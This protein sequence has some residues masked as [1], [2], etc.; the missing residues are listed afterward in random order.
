VK[1]CFEIHWY[2]ELSS[3]M[4][5]AREFALEGREVAVV[6]EIQRAGRGRL[7]RRWLSPK[8]GLW[9]S[10][11]LVQ[12]S[13]VEQIPI[14]TYLAALATC[15]AVEKTTGI[16]PSIKWP[17]DLLFQNKKLAGI[18]LETSIEGNKLN[19]AVLGIGINVNNPSPPEESKAISLREILNKEVDRLFL[20]TQLL[21]MVRELLWKSKE[22]LFALWES[23]CSTLG[24]RVRVLTPQ[25][26]ITG[27]AKGLSPQGALIILEDG[28][29][30][31]EV[32]SGDCIH[33]F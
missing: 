19:Y 4:E 24:K 5:V 11:S 9:L 15:L 8:G 29:E 17:N 16:K 32:F 6:A 30:I 1:H 23:R 18:L 3:T 22:E 31:R 7:G 12:S 28:G 21:K 2:E 33:L 14:L 13:S 20:L 27:I 26:E 25:G 10:L